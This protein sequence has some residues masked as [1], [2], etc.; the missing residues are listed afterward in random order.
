M[1]HITRW[2]WR[3]DTCDCQIYTL[4]DTDLPPDQQVETAV[5]I[6]PNTVEGHEKGTVRCE[7]HTSHTD[8]HEHHKVVYNECKTKNK[9][10]GHLNDGEGV[11]T[12]HWTGQS[13]N[14]VLHVKSSEA[15][16]SKGGKGKIQKD[17]DDDLGA[18]KVLID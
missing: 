9:A 2:L 13:P 7:A 18:G 4:V 12:W 10:H 16:A 8:P 14:R 15:K 11:I 6:A 17:V 1:T 5:E 3:S